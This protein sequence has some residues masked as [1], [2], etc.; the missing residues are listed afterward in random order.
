MENENEYK[1]VVSMGILHTSTAKYYLLKPY[2]INGDWETEYPLLRFS[3][4]PMVFAYHMEINDNDKYDKYVETTTQDV[5]VPVNSDWHIQYQVGKEIFVLKS[6]FEDGLMLTDVVHDLI[7]PDAPPVPEWF[8]EL[9]QYN[10]ELLELDGWNFGAHPDNNR[11]VIALTKS[12]LE[13]I[14][15]WGFT[16][17]KWLTED[18]FSYN[19]RSDPVIAWKD[20]DDLNNCS[21]LEGR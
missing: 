10:Q 11:D 6:E 16:S 15:Y 20:S 18:P 8:A 1:K 9:E 5:I 7:L 3:C 14:A 2:P 21:C 19:F 4:V 17:K 13:K 12:G